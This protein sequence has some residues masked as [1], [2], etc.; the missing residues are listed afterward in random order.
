MAA[1]AVSRWDNRSAPKAVVQAPRGSSPQNRAGL[2][3]F[4]RE[5]CI[6]RAINCMRCSSSQC[7]LLLG[8][9][10]V[11]SRLNYPNSFI[12]PRMYWIPPCNL[13]K[14]RHSS[15]FTFKSPLPTPSLQSAIRSTLSNFLL[16]IAGLARSLYHVIPFSR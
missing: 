14:S 10:W 8:C 6:H 13:F 16:H 3:R 5:V 15:K 1:S 4:T 7:S 12:F 9:D 2:P 11:V